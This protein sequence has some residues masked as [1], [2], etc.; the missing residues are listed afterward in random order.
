MN[1]YGIVSFGV[2]MYQYSEITELHV[3]ASSFCQAACPQCIRTGNPLVI[4]NNMSLMFFKSIVP[5][6]FIKQL[7]KVMFCGNI[8]DPLMNNELLDIILYIIKCNSNIHIDVHTNGSLRNTEYWRNNAFMTKANVKT[9]FALD[10]LED[11]HSI[12]RINT[13]FAKIIENAK[14]Y[15]AAGGIA[16]WHMLV[17]QH[18]LHQVELCR[19]LSIELGF[20][21][22]TSKIT[23]RFTDNSQIISTDFALT[24]TIPVSR[25]T[26]YKDVVANSVIDCE[27]KKIKSVYIDNKGLIWPCCY[28]GLI[29]YK[30]Q[31]TA[32]MKDNVLAMDSVVKQIGGNDLRGRSI[33]DTLNKTWTDIY[34]TALENK[35]IPQCSK[36][37]GVR[38]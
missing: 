36:T 25:I 14:A 8:G 26:N 22:F 18:N 13:V 38:T 16:E 12:Y 15:I 6:D 29:P 1:E 10:G 19:Q 3:E 7:T 23:D 17:F 2:G 24:S 27:V 5:E 30:N 20:Q 11:T 32:F 4:E 28:L 21:S 31:K 35:T 37:C 33:R 9:I 34:N